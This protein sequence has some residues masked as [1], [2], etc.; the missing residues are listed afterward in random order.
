[1]DS[2][3][4]KNT[5]SYDPKTKCW[6]L[7]GKGLHATVKQL[8]ERFNVKFTE[9]EPAKL[10]RQ[11]ATYWRR[12]LQ[13]QEEEQHER[14]K[15]RSPLQGRIKSLERAIAD[16]E[17][18]DPANA[19]LERLRGLLRDSIACDPD[20]IDRGDA[21][22]LHPHVHPA[23]QLLVKNDPFGIM[24]ANAT[25]PTAKA[26]PPKITIATEV[27]HALQ[28]L[29]TRSGKTAH[30]H[31]TRQALNLLSEVCG[32]LEPPQLTVDHWRQFFQR[33]KAVPTWGNVTHSN[34]MRAAKAFVK[35]MG[36]ARNVYFGFLDLPEFTID[37]GDGKKVRYT[38]EQVKTA[39]QHATGV[40]RLQVLL[41]LNC[42]MT[43]DDILLLSPQSIQ[44][45]SIVWQRSKLGEYKNGEKHMDKVPTLKNKLWKATLAA[46][47]EYKF[48]VSEARLQAGYTAFT[49]RHRLPPHKA[50]R[51]TTQQLIEDAAGNVVGRHYRGELSGGTHAKYY[52]DR[53]L[54]E[55]EQAALDT[56]TDAVGTR[57]GL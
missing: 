4:A 56:A 3:R 35:C 41:G 8:Q 21:P 44:G 42:G 27:A 34:A 36:Q 16:L 47:Q 24:A 30:F 40:Q 53:R 15:A 52:A 26:A 43:A 29:L 23:L 32:Q 55:V 12:W 19:I 31:F 37:A 28:V 11:S 25:V 2:V 33:V 46:L 5:G 38:E 50:L 51:K 18:E 6:R 45:E 9:A 57:F 48:D 22:V 13:E 14:Q 17:R 10:E 1:M 54:S 7:R 39:L 20:D 49:R